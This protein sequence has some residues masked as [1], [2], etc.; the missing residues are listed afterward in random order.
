MPAKEKSSEFHVGDDF[1]KFGFFLVANFMFGDLDDKQKATLNRL[2]DSHS[3]LQ[4][5]IFNNIT[6]SQGSGYL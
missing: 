1:K 3:E 2:I 6:D 4:T 5:K